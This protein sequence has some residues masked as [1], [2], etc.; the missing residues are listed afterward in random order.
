MTS[1]MVYGAFQVQKGLMTAGDIIL[2]QSLMMQV[3]KN[4]RERII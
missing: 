4:K 3:G 1:N 2:M